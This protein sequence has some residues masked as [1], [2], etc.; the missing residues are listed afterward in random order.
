MVI[1]FKVSLLIF[2]LLLIISIHDKN[3][4]RVN[5]RY[6]IIFFL[7]LQMFTAQAA[8]K[9]DI[10][11]SEIVLDDVESDPESLAKSEGL[12]QVIV[13]ASGDKSSVNNLVIQKALSKSGTFLTQLGYGEQL[14]QKTL[15]M[16]FNPPQVQALLNQAELPY[17]SDTRS[18]LIVW[19][20][21]EG[22]YGREIQW[23]H[24]GHET[25]EQI[26]MH[27]E[28]RGLPI[29][30]PVGDIEDITAI[31]GPDLWGGFIDP[32]SKASQRYP[33]DAVLVVRIQ[34]AADGQLIR[35]TLYD[36][37]PQ[38]MINSKREPVTG[39]TSGQVFVALEAMIDEI[40]N[41]YAQKSAVKQ[42]GVAENT[43][44][45]QFL[46][47]NSS[48]R[49]FN[50]ERELKKLSSVAGIEVKQVVGST[51]TFEVHLLG[52]EADFAAEVEQIHRVRALPTPEP[53]QIQ[54]VLP[55]LTTTDANQDLPVISE[56]TIGAEPVELN[57]PE[58]SSAM[59]QLLFDLGN[60]E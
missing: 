34:K 8:V 22:Q 39:T 57:Q 20:I 11:S 7:G 14:G 21:Q 44:T 24:S 3:I 31:S 12:K 15:K 33:S 49:F 59:T 47:V 19:V 27:A 1:D 56:N 5:M 18:S 54:P 6:F 28:A 46:G 42:S 26:K 13:K 32:I 4:F 55:V 36:E 53:E 45:A 41:Y 2:L 37:K 58:T 16:R 29:T 52:S 30:I 60:D 48:V 51:V 17:W 10:F 9:V 38:F 50:L 43:L 35:W 40:G 23:E 25:L